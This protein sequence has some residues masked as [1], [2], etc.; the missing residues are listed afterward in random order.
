MC[1]Y[2]LCLGMTYVYPSAVWRESVIV[3]I[4][5]PSVSGACACLHSLAEDEDHATVPVSS[6]PSIYL[7]IYLSLSQVGHLSIYLSVPVSSRLSI[8]TVSVSSRLISLYLSILS[9]SQVGYLSISVLVSSR[10]SIFLSISILSLSQVG[11]LSISLY[12]SLSQV[13]C[14]SMYLS[15]YCPCLK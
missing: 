1:I 8:Y 6:R 9:L 7:F 5:S 14:L 15:L 11:Y 12:L 13:G 3:L 10:L 2:R 4:L